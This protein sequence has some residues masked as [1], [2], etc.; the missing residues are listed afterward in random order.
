MLPPRLELR[1]SR[2]LLAWILLLHLLT[3]IVIFAVPLPWA[4]KTAC[5]LAIAISLW[6]YYRR[7]YRGACS[8]LR[9]QNMKHWRLL[10]HGVELEAELSR[11][12]VFRFLVI[13][14]F[15]LDSGKRC[16][17]LI[18]EDAMEK[19]SHRRLRSAL[20]TEKGF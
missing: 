19:D 18:P 1:P 2:W 6:F 4:G 9:P 17:V 14:G 13:L 15:T 5:Y 8:E 10:R 7:D 3:A 20:R 11:Y 16:V 12:Q